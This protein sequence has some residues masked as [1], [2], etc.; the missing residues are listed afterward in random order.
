MKIIDLK[1]DKTREKQLKFVVIATRYN[2]E[3]VYVR[4][5][6]RDTWEVPGG[7]I[8]IGETVH[9]AARRELYEESG[10]IEYDLFDV[11]DY[12][13]NRDNQS[14]FGRLLFAEVKEFS[15][16]PESEI[17][18]RKVSNTPGKFTYES[19]QPRLI[20]IVTK[21]LGEEYDKKNSLR[22]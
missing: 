11:C 15:D 8:E 1:I 9:N 16:I 13:V 3:W 20:E 18:E 12:D 6:K 7:H 17:A 4:H 21:W 22:R 19:I 5:E 10:A 14:S 2:N